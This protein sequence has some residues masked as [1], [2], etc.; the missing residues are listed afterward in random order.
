[1]KRVLIVEDSE[2]CAV[3][4]EIALESLPEIDLHVARSAADAIRLLENSGHPVSVIITDLQMPGLSGLDL[5]KLL[6]SQ[7][8]FVAVPVIIISG[9]SDP[10]LPAQALAAG[11]N[12][13]Y[14]KPYS[15]AEVRKT[16]EQFLS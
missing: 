14:T 2:T 12:A 5:L 8:R 7:S 9:D 16:V 10:R 11:A 4:L 1:M 3:T 15:P 13:F 6:R